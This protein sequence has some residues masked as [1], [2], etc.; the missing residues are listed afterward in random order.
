[1][2]SVLS[3]VGVFLVFIIGPIALLVLLVALAFGGM[4]GLMSW[5]RNAGRDKDPAGVLS[6]KHLPRAIIAKAGPYSDSK[7]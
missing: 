3:G 4:F 2:S 7:P 1:M 6:G 5:H